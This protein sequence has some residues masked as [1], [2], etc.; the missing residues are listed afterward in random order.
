ME[1]GYQ[2]TKFGLVDVYKVQNV[3][4][5]QRYDFIICISRN[6]WKRSESAVVQFVD[7]VISNGQ[8]SG[9][10]DVIIK[11]DARDDQQSNGIMVF[12]SSLNSQQK[13]K[14]QGYM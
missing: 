13:K 2:G 11:K 4:Q 8:G 10:D 6:Q 7:D 5:W 3:Q 12:G 1:K 14:Y 9:N